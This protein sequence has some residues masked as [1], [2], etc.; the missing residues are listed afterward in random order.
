MANELDSAIT[1]KKAIDNIDSGDFLLPAIQR[2]FVWNTRQIEMLFDSIMQDY[3]INTFMFWEVTDKEI[4]NKFRFYS[5]LK[6]YVEYKGGNNEEVNTK[7]YK[8]FKAIIDGQ[9]R[10]NSLYIGLKGSY[11]YKNYIYRKKKYR[12]DEINYPSRNLYL[13]ILNPIENDENKKVYDFKFLVCNNHKKENERT[14]KKIID[15]NDQEQIVECF[16]F[17]VSKILEF[18]NEHNVVMFLSEKKLDIGGFAGETLLKLF[19]LVNEK[20]IINFYLEKDQNFDKVLYEFIRTNSG[21]T[22]LSFAD[23]LM[24]IITAS[25]EKGKSSKG[26][27]EEIDNVIRQVKEIGFNIS[28]DFV[29]KTTLVLFSSD[30]KFRLKN[31][32]SSTIQ[33]IKEEWG[34]IT[35]CIKSTFE[36]IKSL[37]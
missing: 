37:F 8:D 1:I 18:T 3:P 7:G 24:S 21:G 10:L 36:L 27:R 33:K 19:K 35:L 22:T 31:F 11:A 26:A 13:D 4:K 14:T 32:D 15:E 28:Q 6:K 12:E 17:D 5:F 29:L 9:Q 16:W 20:P 34:V 30:I 2:R 23:L 25:W